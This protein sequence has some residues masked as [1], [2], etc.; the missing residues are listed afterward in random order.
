[1]QIFNTTLYLPKPEPKK[2]RKKCFYNFELRSSLRRM[3]ETTSNARDLVLRR[4]SF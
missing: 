2:R 4:Q 3:N 1:M